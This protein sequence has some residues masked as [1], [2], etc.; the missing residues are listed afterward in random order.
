MRLKLLDELVLRLA[1]VELFQMVLRDE[2]IEHQRFDAD[3]VTA[4][5]RRQY[6]QSRHGFP[7]VHLVELAGCGDIEARLD[8]LLLDFRPHFRV[9]ERDMQQVMAVEH[10]PDTGSLQQK[11]TTPQPPSS[12]SFLKRE[13]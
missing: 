9:N 11:P 8:E 1:A 5:I 12:A 10:L 6:F 2:R 3:K 7:V 4:H 13:E